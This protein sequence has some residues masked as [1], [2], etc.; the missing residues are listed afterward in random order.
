MPENSN[1]AT[2]GTANLAQNDLSNHSS[3]LSS[4]QIIMKIIMILQNMHPYFLR[5]MKMQ[6][7]K[8]QVIIEVKKLLEK[9]K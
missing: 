9:M 6:E 8:I 7:K 5:A 3:F 4:K 1:A 2:D